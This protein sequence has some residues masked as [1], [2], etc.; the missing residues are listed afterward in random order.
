[1]ETAA[2][3]AASILNR[4]IFKPHKQ[5]GPANSAG[6]CKVVNETEG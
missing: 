5:T 6:A 2:D 1:M 4:R 3:S